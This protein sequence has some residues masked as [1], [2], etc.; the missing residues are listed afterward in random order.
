[1]FEYNKNIKLLIINYN[2]EFKKELINLINDRYEISDLNIEDNIIG[3]SRKDLMYYKFDR[4][5]IF[6][7]GTIYKVKGLINIKNKHSKIIIITETHK[8]DLKY[9]ID[10]S[11]YPPGCV[12]YYGEMPFV[13]KDHQYTCKFLFDRL[14]PLTKVE[15]NIFINSPNNDDFSFIDLLDLP[16]DKNIIYKTGKHKQN[17][18][19]LFDTFVYY[20]ANKYFDPRPRLML[21]SYF[22]GKKVL[23]YNI[24]NIKD[25]SY[26]RYKDL[27]KNG[28]S[29]RF[30]TKDDEVIRQFI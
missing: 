20:H 24:H 14:K 12:E 8:K 25:G 7:Y 26:Y 28:I 4:L 19:E 17:L 23:Y 29:H 1:M 9:Y 13:Y 30:L 2:Q 15:P 27:I 22:Y 5:L 6:D 16:K 11:F 21:E 18:F 10:K 3:I